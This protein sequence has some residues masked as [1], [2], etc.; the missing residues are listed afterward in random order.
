MY[1]QTVAAGYTPTLKSLSLLL[2]C[3]RKH[4]AQQDKSLSEDTL[5]PHDDIP[6]DLPSLILDAGGLY[7]PRAFVFFEVRLHIF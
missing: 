5:F 4:E 7:D 6:K 1:R 2:G 3:L